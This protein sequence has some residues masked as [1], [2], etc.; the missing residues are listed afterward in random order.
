MI[1]RPEPDADADRHYEWWAENGAEIEAERE[2][3]GD[4]VHLLPWEGER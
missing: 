3:A 1:V 4:R 2:R